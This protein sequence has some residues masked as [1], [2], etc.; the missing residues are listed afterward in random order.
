MI[1]DSSGALV[2]QVYIG[3]ASNAAVATY[4]AQAGLN[5]ESAPNRISNVT[6][7]GLREVI[8][9]GDKYTSVTSFT[10]MSSTYD[11]G[12]LNL[13]AQFCT[14]TQKP[15]SIYFFLPIRAKPFTS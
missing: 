5:L 12:F 4:Y 1:N 3:Q 7:I 10:N 15:N 8:V 11:L 14:V 6:G 13:N 9:L 2:D